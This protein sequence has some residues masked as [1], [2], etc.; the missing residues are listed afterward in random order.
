[1][2]WWKHRG[3]SFFIISLDIPENFRP[4]DRCH[5]ICKPG[6]SPQGCAVVSRRWKGAGLSEVDYMSRSTTVAL[7]MSGDVT[8][9]GE[10]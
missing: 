4:G 10:C 5:G 1:M 9:P 3:P 8:L 7:V 2:P 6:T